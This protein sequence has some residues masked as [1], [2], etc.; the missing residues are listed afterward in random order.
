[1]GNGKL[2]YMN[3]KGNAIKTFRVKVN[4]C[5]EINYEN[6]NSPARKEVV[7]IQIS[8]PAS[9]LYFHPRFRNDKPL[10]YFTRSALRYIHIQSGVHRA[11]LCE[12]YTVSKQRLSLNY[13]QKTK[14]PSLGGGM[15][16]NK[17]ASSSYSFFAVSPSTIVFEIVKS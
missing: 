6:I 17:T 8:T 10:L 3:I 15:R 2:T 7:I 5:S 13:L 9:P 14:Y 1:M 11:S 16:K 4:H 12:I